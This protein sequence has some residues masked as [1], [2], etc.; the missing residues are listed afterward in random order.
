MDA[1]TLPA[2]AF[3]AEREIP[4]ML[5]G[6][7]SRNAIVIDTGEVRVE[8]D[9]M[10]GRLVELVSGVVNVFPEETEGENN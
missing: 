1:S 3:G 9:G 6:K 7:D 5:G 8:G 2:A 10:D 4:F